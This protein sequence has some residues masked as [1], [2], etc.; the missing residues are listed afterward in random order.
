MW[1]LLSIVCVYV[2]VKVYFMF[3]VSTFYKL[4]SDHLSV[5]YGA[6][7][8]GKS[9]LAAFYA[10]KALKAGY[11]VYSNFPITGCYM[12]DKHDLGRYAMQNCLIIVDEAGIDW[13]NRDFAYNFNKKSGGDKALE[14]FKKH[15]HEKAEIMCFSQTFDDMDKKIFDLADRYYIVSK[16]LF[17]Y[18]QTIVARRIKVKPDIDKRTDQP[19]DKYSFMFFGK[20]RI[21]AKPLWKYFD[22]YDTMGLPEKQNWKIYGQNNSDP[23]GSAAAPA[24][25]ESTDFDK[26]LELQL[27]DTEN[28]TA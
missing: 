6:P 26:W 27:A 13:N 22:S 25:V 2:I 23:V 16:G 28:A 21:F 1:K 18:P 5:F 17:P 24:L 14:F 10:R 3:P 4:R 7:G 20:T 8:S 9:T 12:Y 15:R 11:K 19:Y